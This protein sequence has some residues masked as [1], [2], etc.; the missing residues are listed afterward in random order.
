MTLEEAVAAAED[1][2]AVKLSR[3]NPA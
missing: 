2:V 3:L 1:I